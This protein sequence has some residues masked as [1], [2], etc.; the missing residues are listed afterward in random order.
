MRTAEGRLVPYEDSR[1]GLAVAPW[2][3]QVGPPATAGA[4]RTDKLGEHR[5]LEFVTAMTTAIPGVPGT[6][7]DEQEHPDEDGDDPD[8]ESG[9]PQARN[10]EHGPEHNGGKIERKIAQ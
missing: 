2:A 10:D 6:P 4:V 9:R 1:T 7:T 3:S 8:N 5:Y